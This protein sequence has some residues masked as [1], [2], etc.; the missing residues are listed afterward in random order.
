MEERNI[1]ISERVLGLLRRMPSFAD[2]SDGQI[3][4]LF[5]DKGLR[6]REYR[7]G[8][9]IIREGD[10]DSWVYYL[11]SGQARVLAQEAQ[12][13]RLGEYGDIF[14]E[15][16]PLR[17]RPR[18]ASVVAESAVTCFAIDLSILDR[19]PPDERRAASRL[20][21]E[22]ITDVV[23]DRLSRANLDAAALRRDL[24]MAA[25]ALTGVNSRVRELERRVLDL[26]RENQEL[27][28]QCGK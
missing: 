22:L 24:A 9:T 11:I 17:G 18:N 1:T 4:A 2:L 5:A 16:G 14:G 7:A 25:S 13:A 20:F 19:L 6:Y 3:T 15:M 23:H 28:R 27:R 8:E 21:E 10:H 12:V 26:T